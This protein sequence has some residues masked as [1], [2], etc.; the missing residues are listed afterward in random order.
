[1]MDWIKKQFRD[2]LTE[3]DGK[4]VCVARVMGIGAA[5]QGNVL[6]VWDVVVQHAHFDFQAYGL[7]MGATLTALGVALGMKKDTQP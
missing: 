1:M 7:G 4:T 5:L 3:P 6:C 2:V